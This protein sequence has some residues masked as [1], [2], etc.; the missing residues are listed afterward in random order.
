MLKRKLGNLEV[1]VMGLGCMGMHHA[2]GPAADEKEMIALIRKALD[3]GIAFFD[4]AEIYGSGDNEILLG[5][6]LKNQKNAV[7]ATKFGI[8]ANNG[9]ILET[10]SRPSTIRKS[11]EMSLK[12]LQVEAIDLY[13]Q[14]RVDPKV[15]LEEVAQTMEQLMREGKIKHWGMSECTEQ[16]LELAHGI[17]PVAAVQSRYSVMARQAEK[18]MIP[19]CEK[20]H[21][22]FVAFSPLANG[23]LS[24]A[25][26]GNSRFDPETDYRSF[27]PQFQPQNMQIHQKRM[28]RLGQIARGKNSSPAQISLV[29]VL[30]Q[31]P[32]IVPIPG[33]RKPERLEENAKAAEIV[34]TESELRELSEIFENIPAD[35]IYLGAKVR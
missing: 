28:E 8:A 25:Y 3:L 17:C 1:S 19:L 23:F 22:G 21:I 31:K 35:Q 7:I 13:Y 32:F 9:K 4:T 11:A 5:K 33:T 26:D 10:D 27:L 2:Y 29:W 12:R 20:L 16:E 24:A 15:P 6:A 14:H 18:G 30:S 34:L